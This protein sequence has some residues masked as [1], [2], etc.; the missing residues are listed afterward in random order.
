MVLPVPGNRDRID[1][2]VEPL[3]GMLIP[4]GERG[5]QLYEVK[6]RKLVSCSRPSKH[7]LHLESRI[8]NASGSAV[9][10]RSGSK[11]S[12]SRMTAKTMWQNFLATATLWGL[13][14][15]RFL[16]W[17]A[18][19]FGSYWQVLLSASQTALLR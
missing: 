15:R 18:L 2:D 1:V 16:L 8:S 7:T 17:R 19:G 4:S 5:D 11:A 9:P 14:L 13:P 10:Y 12:W 3:G 6:A